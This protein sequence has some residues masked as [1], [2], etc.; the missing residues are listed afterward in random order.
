[1]N[2][3]LGAEI[4]AKHNAERAH[5]ETSRYLLQLSQKFREEEHGKQ[6]M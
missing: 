4:E 1:M 3:V 6:A 2:S 5:Q